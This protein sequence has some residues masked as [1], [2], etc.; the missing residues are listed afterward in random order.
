MGDINWFGSPKTKAYDFMYRLNCDHLEDIAIDYFGKKFTYGEMFQGIETFA[1][2][3]VS[4]GVLPG[5]YI[6]LVLPNIPELVFLFYACNRIGAVV[7]LLDPRTNAEA[8]V[9]RTNRTSSKILF[10]LSDLVKDKNEPFYEKLKVEK[11]VSITPAD[12]IRGLIPYSTTAMLI[13]GVYFLKG[14]GTKSV[15]R[16]LSH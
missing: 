16:V 13:R 6:T 9:E 5:D 11:I 3:L 10:V 7:N 1:G 8:I 2:A 12:S 4:S 15:S 14:G